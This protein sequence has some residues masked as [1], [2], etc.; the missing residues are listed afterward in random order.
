MNLTSA[1]RNKINVEKLRD[2][3]P[4]LSRVAPRSPYAALGVEFPVVAARL[5]DKC[6]ATLLGQ[7]GEYHYACPLDR[8]FFEASGLNAD[9]LREFIAT[10][11]NDAEVEAWMRANATTARDKFQRW[12]R[13]FRA[14]PLWHLL[15]FEDWLHVRR[16]SRGR[17]EI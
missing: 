3:A 17:P 7:N 15:E 5:T 14:N 1:V 9:L 16:S 4:D 11:A 8:R 12:C 10:G 6:R 13:W 2:L